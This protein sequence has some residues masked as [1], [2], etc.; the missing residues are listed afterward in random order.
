M[1]IHN[2]IREEIR[3]LREYRV[4]EIS[5]RILLNTNE[6]PYEIPQEIHEKVMETVARLPLNRYPHPTSRALREVISSRFNIKA[7]QIVVGNGSDELIQMIAIAF[8]GAQGSVLIHPPTFGIYTVSAKSIG[9]RVIEVPLLPDWEIDLDGMLDKIREFQPNVIFITYPNN[10]T[11]NCFPLESLEA[12]LQAAEGV[13]VIDEAYAD[14]SRKSCLHLFNRY[15]HLIIMRTLSKIGLAGLRVGF[16]FA[17]NVLITYLNK[18]K[19]PFN[20]NSLSEAIA[21]I[22]L[23]HRD[24]IEP[25]IEKIIVE[26]RHLIEGLAQIPGIEPFPSETNFVLF[27]VAWGAGEAYEGLL[28]QGIRIRRLNTNGMEE[29]LRVSVG[30]PEENI[31]FL[32][33][34]AEIAKEVGQ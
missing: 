33:T 17:N 28:K 1:A 24:L 12:I 23:E 32:A 3:E 19:P 31:E 15:E 18:V 7:D 8:G 10:P 34:L 22:V 13:V 11:A 9:Q 29:Y 6:N 5:A 2:R 4:E 14:F 20:L 21:M 26:R 27:H 16:L 25:Q 30:K